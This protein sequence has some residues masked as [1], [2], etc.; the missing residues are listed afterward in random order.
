[1]M[2]FADAVVSFLFSV[3][4]EDTEVVAFTA[5]MAANDNNYKAMTCHHE[6]YHIIQEKE[7]GG[8]LRGPPETHQ[9]PIVPVLEA[10]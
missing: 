10:G 7:E 1:M 5:A 3:T 8:L 4:R 2:L 9:S 6:S